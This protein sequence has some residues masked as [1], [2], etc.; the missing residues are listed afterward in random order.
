MTCACTDCACK[1][2]GG[3]SDWL[4]AHA[5]LRAL[6]VR[7]SA[8]YGTDTDRFENF[9][10]VAEANGQPPE[11]YVAERMLEKL[12]RAFNMIRAGD[13]RAVKEWLDLA[14]LALCA[15]ALRRRV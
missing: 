6:H 11:Y 10:A 8:T 3:D 9:S 15:E 5:E 12:T 2:A 14:S 13:S 1:P 7:K 4:D